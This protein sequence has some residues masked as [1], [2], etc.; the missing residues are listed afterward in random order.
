MSSVAKTLPSSGVPAKR[1]LAYLAAGASLSSLANEADAAVVHVVANQD[2]DGFAAAGGQDVYSHGLSNPALLSFLHVDLNDGFGSGNA[3]FAITGA[4]LASVAGVNVGTEQSPII[5]VNNLNVGA[6][7]S[8]LTSFVS[9]GGVAADLAYGNI[10]G[11]FQSAGEGLLGFRF[12]V[13]NGFQYGWARVLMDGA[14]GNTFRVVDFAYL[15]TDGGGGGFAAG[16]L[17][18]VPEPASLGLLAF[19]AAGVAAMRRR[20]KESLGEG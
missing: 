14:A 2:L 1:W 17:T 4:T 9:F 13:G 20:K 7:L 16:D 12:D 18:A 15:T 8:Q 19:G 3:L 11:N 5:Y 10:G 6:V